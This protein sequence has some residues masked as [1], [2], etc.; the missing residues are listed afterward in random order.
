MIIKH[1]FKSDRWPEFRTGC[2]TAEDCERLLNYLLRHKAKPE[3]MRNDFSSDSPMDIAEELELMRM[4]Q[5]HLAYHIIA[6]YPDGEAH[7]WEPQSGQRIQELQDAL[8]VEKGFWVRHKNHWHG[9][10]CAM[11]ERGGQVRLATIGEEGQSIPVA[12]SF[13]LMAEKWEDETPGCQK[14]G[15]KGGGDS[16]GLDLSRESLAMAER[17]FMQGTAPT[18]VPRKVMLR[19]RVERMVML[20][21]SFEQLHELA[22][23]EGISVQYK[24]DADGKV[25]GISFAADGVSLRGREAGYSFPQLQQLY[26]HE[27]RNPK[28][29][30]INAVRRDVSLA[31]S[32]RRENRRETFRQGAT[33]PYR[34]NQQAW[35]NTGGPG[36]TADGYSA[37]LGWT[38]KALRSLTPNH[39]FPSLIVEFIHTLGRFCVQQ[40]YVQRRRYN[41]PNDSISFP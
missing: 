18:P 6:S 13:R 30:P 11:N 38:E 14:T 26:E 33:S 21:T 24:H 40:D 28:N 37:H 36:S 12:R 41:P 8:R 27:S 4:Q 5:K 1:H 19:A 31:G 15:R 3:V 35:E 32:N 9:F 22:A 34:P 17:Q 39:D 10:L 25:L 7:L 23:Q 2:T 20:S 16:H 29:N